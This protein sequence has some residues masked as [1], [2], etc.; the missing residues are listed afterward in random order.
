VEPVAGS[1]L[2][3]RLKSE[4]IGKLRTLCDLPLAITA[5]EAAFD[6]DIGIVCALEQPELIAVR[7]ALGGAKAWKEIGDA[8]FAHVYRETAIQTALGKSLR[9]VATASTSMGLTAAAIATTQLAL[10]FRPRLIVM[11]GIA[12]GNRIEFRRLG[13]GA[14]F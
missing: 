11:I 12:A 8:K 13:N 9:V 1:P 10:Q 4:G 5:T 3:W 2:K 6:S 7:E 14:R